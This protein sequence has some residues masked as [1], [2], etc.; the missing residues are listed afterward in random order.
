MKF[1]H[2]RRDCNKLEEDQKHNQV[3]QIEEVD[4]GSQSSD[5]TTAAGPTTSTVR[6]VSIQRVIQEHPVDHDDSCEVFTLHYTNSEQ[7]SSQCIRVLSTGVL[8]PKLPDHCMSQN[9]STFDLIYSDDNEDWTLC[10]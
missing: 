1:G 6:R 10:N 9:L 2:G 8:K 4:T 7:V 5:A 3:R